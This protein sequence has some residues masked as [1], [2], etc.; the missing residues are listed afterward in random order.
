MVPGDVVLMDMLPYFESGKVNRKALQELYRRTTASTD[1]A[2]S[3]DSDDLR[4]I[5]DVLTATLEM[6]VSPDSHLTSM[7][8][9]SLSSIRLASKLSQAGLPRLDAAAL[10]GCTTPRDIEAHLAS[11]RD[12]VASNSLVNIAGHLSDL[13]EAAMQHES[14]V[15]CAEEVED[16]LPP[17]AV[18]VAMLNETVRDAHAYCNWI[19]LEIPADS[20]AAKIQRCIIQLAERHSLLRSGFAP[21]AGRRYTHALVTWKRLTPNQ[22]DVVGQFDR[23]FVISD[24]EQLL[25]PCNFQILPGEHGTRVLLCIHH[26]LYDQWSVDLMKLD[27]EALLRGRELDPPKLFRSVALHHDH[28]IAEAC[29]GPAMEFWQDQ[30]GSS[31]PS[32]L[33]LM[34]GSQVPSQV[35][36]TQW[37]TLDLPFRLFR[38]TIRDLG[39]SAPSVFQSALAYLLGC[40]TGS[41]DVTFASVFSGRNISV[42]GIDQVFGPCL[43]TLPVRVNYGATRTCRDLLRLVH[44]RNQAIQ[45]HVL[46]PLAQIMAEN[47][48][49]QGSRMFDTLFVWQETS[50]PSAQLVRE[51][52]SSDRNEFDLVVELEPRADA[53]DVRATFEQRLL[54]VEQ[55]KLL[56]RQLQAVV[57]VMLHRPDSAVKEL[58]EH[59]PQ[60][61]LS[62]GNASYSAA[63]V[64]RNLAH[65]IA[66]H[67]RTQPDAT[68]LEFFQRVD[69]GNETMTRVSYRDLERRTN[70]MAHFLLSVVSTPNELICICMDKSVEMYV[71]IVATVK[72]G[73]GYL[74]LVPGTPPKR[75][76]AVFAQTNVKMCICNP[77]LVETVQELGLTAIDIFRLD[78]EA[79]SSLL[80]IEQVSG[81]GVAYTVFTSGSTGQPKGVAVTMDNLLG[82]LQVLS[83][84]YRV[85]TG[86]RLL[87]ACSQAFDVSVFEIFFA[88]Y[89]GIALV[90][91]P[92]EVLFQDIERIIDMLSVTHL[93]LTPTVAAL[94]D[95]VKVPRVRFLVTAGEGMNGLV[96]RSWAGRGLHQGYG[97]SETTNICTIKMDMA[98]TD[99]RGNV[100]RPFRNTS[101]FVVSLDGPFAPLPSG[102]FGEFVFGGEQVFKGY[103]AMEQ[104][105]AEKIIHHPRF[106]RLYKS[107]DVGRLL[108]DGSLLIAGR[109]DDQ[110]KIRG[111]RVELGEIRAVLLE[112]PDVHDAAV[113]LHGKDAVEQMLAAFVVPRK[114]EHS[115][116][117]PSGALCDVDALDLARLYARLE[118]RLPAYMI[119][120]AIVPLPKMPVTSQGKL[121]QRSLDALLD[122]M[123]DGT[124]NRLRHD[125]G[126]AEVE[127]SWSG[128]EKCIADEV[129]DHLGMGSARITRGSSFFALGLNSL[130]AIALARRLSG[131]LKRNV[132]V[133]LI[134]KNPTVVRLARAVGEQSSVALHTTSAT[135]LPL[136]LVREVA[137]SS[138]T[139]S[140]NIEDTLPCTP[141]QQAMLSASAAKSSAYCNTVWIAIHGDAARVKQC[142]ESA[143]RRHGILRTVFPTTRDPEHPHVQLVLRSIDLPWYEQRPPPE[144]KLSEVLDSHCSQVTASVPFM[145]QLFD[146]ADGSYLCLQMHHAISDGVSLALMLQEVEQLYSGFDLAPAVSF[147]PFLEEVQHHNSDAA[148]EFWAS[149][150]HHFRPT[151]L[152]AIAGNRTEAV[153]TSLHE[154]LTVDPGELYCFCRQYGVTQLALFQAALMMTLSYS[155][156]ALDVCIGSVTSGRTVA[157]EG[158]ERLIAPCFNT[159]PV[160]MDLGTIT[161]IVDLVKKLTQLNV[162]LLPFQL[163]S[164]RR[165]QSFSSA[166]ATR[167]FDCLLLLQ[168][169][170]R[171]LDSDVWSIRHEDGEMNFP[172]VLEM[173]PDDA[174]FDVCWHHLQ[175]S[176]SSETVAKIQNLFSVVLKQCLQFP[177]AKIADNADSW[178]I[179]PRGFLAASHEDEHRES[180]ARHLDS[181][182]DSPWGADEDLVRCVFA[183]LARVEKMRVKKHTSMYQI[184]LDS[185]NAPQVAAKLRDRG[186]HVD[187]ADVMENLTPADIAAVARQKLSVHVDQPGFDLHA[188]DQQYRRTVLDTLNARTEDIEAVRPCTAV[189]C[190]MLAQSMQSDGKLYINHITYAMPEGASQSRIETA[191]RHVQAN[192]QILR[193]S[194]LHLEDHTAPFVMAVFRADAT[195]L[196]VLAARDTTSLEKIELDATKLIH[197]SP[198]VPAW[199][200]SIQMTKRGGYMM[201]SMSHALYD[202]ES[203]QMFA[204]DFYNTLRGSS[205]AHATSMDS[206]LRSTLTAERSHSPSTEAF[207]A[208]KVS[209]LMPSRFPD[210]TPTVVTDGALRSEHHVCSLQFRDIK[211][212]C[213][214]EEVTIQA[215]GQAA[216]ALLLSAYVGET[217][218]TFG[219]VLSGRTTDS[220]GIAFPSITTIPVPC[221]VDRPKLQLVRDML[222]FNTALQRHRHC[223]LSQIQQHAGCSG[224]SLFDTV[225]VY[226]RT[227]STKSSLSWPIVRET[228]GVEY[229]A[230]LEL[231]HGSGEDVTVRLTF[232]THRIPLEHGR[233]ILGQYELLLAQIV[234]GLERTAS[235]TH[236]MYSILPAKTPEITSAELLLHDFVSSGA[237][238]WP[239]S[240]ALEFV[241]DDD[242]SVE[243]WS[244]KQFDEVS[245]Q[246]AHLLIR[247]GVLPGSMVAVCMEKCP[248][249]SFAFV[250]ILKTGCSF[251][252]LDPDLPQSRFDFILQDSRAVLLLSNRE[253]VACTDA[254]RVLKIERGSLRDYPSGRPC[255]QPVSPDQTCYCLYT[256]GTTGTPKGCEITH[257]N[258]VQAMLAFQR[259]FAGHWT[260]ASRWLQFASYWF[261]VSVLEQFWSWSVGITVVGAPRDLI[262][263]NLTGFIESQRITHIDLT[264]SLARLVDPR[265]VPTLWGGVFITGGEALK[266]AIIDAWGSKRTVCNAYGPTEAT[267]GVTMN[268]FIGSAAK[269]S[270]I[271]HQFDNVGTY[272]LEQESD[273]PVMLGGV[274]EL[275]VAGK[276]VGKGYLNR[277]ELSAK[278]FP[279]LHRFGER[280][281]RT[282]DLV[283]MLAD[284]SFIFLGR[285]DSQA[286]LRGQRLEIDEIDAAIRDGSSDISGVASLVVKA[287]KGEKQTLVS[288]VASNSPDSDG[289]IKLQL[290]RNTRQT[291]LDAYHACRRRLPGY[292]VPSHIIPVSRLPL[293]ANN[294]S[295]DK[296]LASFFHSLS[297]DDV[298]QLRA[299]PNVKPATGAE[300]KICNLFCQVLGLDAEQLD[301]ETSLFSLGL[302]SISAITFASVLKR[303]GYNNATV[304]TVMKHATIADLASALSAPSAASRNIDD[305]VEQTKLWLRAYDQRHRSFAASVMSVNGS[306]IET[307]APCT[308]LQQG[309]IVESFKANR[310]PY[311][312]EFQ[313]RLNGVNLEKLKHSFQTL[314]DQVQVLRTSFIRT[315][316]G[317]AQVVLL[318]K[319]VSLQE[320]S[321]RADRAHDCLSECK[322][323]WIES[324]ADELVAPF[325]VHFV[326]SPSH[327]LMAIFVHHALYDG[328]SYPLLMGQLWRIYR[329]EPTGDRGPNFTVALPYG[330]LRQTPGA[331]HFWTQRLR[332]VQYVPFPR[333]NLIDKS[334]DS[335]IQRSQ[336]NSHSVQSASKQLGVPYQ[337][338]V[339]ACFELALAEILPSAQAYGLVISG[340]S[341]DLDDSD[342]VLGPMFNTLLQPLRVDLNSLF[343][344]HVRQCHDWM[345][346]TLPF[347]QSSLRDIRKW[348]NMSPGS[349]VFDILLVF[350]IQDAATEDGLCTQ[351][352]SNPIAEH[353]VTCEIE[354][355]STGNLNITLLAQ[356]E[357]LDEDTVMA[358]LET[359]TLLLERAAQKPDVEI[360]KMF[361]IVQHATSQPQQSRK[362]Q[363]LPVED[364]HESEWSPEA[365]IIRQLIAQVMELKEDDI[366]E[367]TSIFA[368]GMDSIDAVKLASRLKSVGIL[369]SVSDVMHCETITR[370]APV[371]RKK[372]KSHAPREHVNIR[373]VEKSLLAADIG[374]GPP[375]DNAD[376][377][378][379]L[380]ATSSQ[381]AIIAD[382]L[383]SEFRQYFNHD[384]LRLDRDLDLD[385]LKASWQTVVDASPILRTSFA[386]IQDPKIDFTFALCVHKPRP[387]RF[388]EHS[389]EDLASVQE[390]IDQIREDVRRTVHILPPLRLGIITVEQERY[391]ILALSHALYD[392]HSIAMLHDDVQRAYEKAYTSR[393]GID[394]A[395]ESA[396]GATEADAKH[397]WTASLSGSKAIGFPRRRSPV[398]RSATHRVQIR[399]P[400][401]ASTVRHF[402]KAQGV[403]IQALA[404]TCWAITL[405]HHVRSLEVLFGVVMACRDSDDEQRIMFPMMNTVVFRAVMHGLRTE[406][407]RFMQAKGASLRR[408]QRTPL[409]S[410]QKWCAGMIDK[411]SSI[412]DNAL[413]D[414]LFI[415]QHRHGAGGVNDK[416]LYQSVE[417]TSDIEYP[418]AV[419]MEVL[420][421]ELFIRAACKDSVFDHQGTVKLAQ[422]MSEVLSV[423]LTDPDAPTVT[424]HGELVSLCGLPSFSPLSLASTRSP[425]QQKPE[426]DPAPEPNSELE[427]RIMLTLAQVSG[428]ALD[429]MTPRSTIESIGIDSISA[430]KVAA[431]LRKE[432]LYLTVSDI[433]QHKTAQ[434]MARAECSKSKRLPSAETPGS[435]MIEARRRPYDSH[436]ISVKAGVQVAD[437][438]TILPATS[439]QVYLL[440]LWALTHG[441]TF[442]SKFTYRINVETNRGQIESAWTALV[443]HHGI[444]RTIFCTTEDNEEPVVQVVLRK[445]TQTVSGSIASQWDSRSKQLMSLHYEE[446]DL[447]RLIHLTIHHALYDA[448]SL[449]LLMNDFSRLLTDRALTSPQLTYADFLALSMGPASHER[450]KTFWQAYFR[451]AKPVKLLQPAAD[452]H[453]G[454]VEALDPSLLSNMSR[455]ER[456]ARRNSISTQALLFAAYARAYA[457]LANSAGLA[458]RDDRDV[459]IGIYLANRAHLPDLASLPCPTLNLVPLRV[460]TPRRGSLM[461]TAQQIH[462]DL[463]SFGTPE[464]SS[465]GLWQIWQWTGVKV[466]TF[467]NF[468]RLPE[469]T[470]LDAPDRTEDVITALDGERLRR[471]LEVIEIEESKEAFNLQ[472]SLSGLKDLEGYCVS[473]YSV[474]V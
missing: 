238:H 28:H 223:S 121:D 107:G 318:Q 472:E 316:E 80:Q 379:M 333:L 279:F 157:I 416:P 380:P 381:E 248:E 46:T 349:P 39:V 149:Q 364:N 377:E 246:V 347:Q 114:C 177:L 437:I 144:T 293:T 32:L 85:Q 90:S 368:L 252:A 239:D 112:D 155:Q 209:S 104:L 6:E 77:G 310:R 453:L 323:Q 58:A 40:Y 385:R 339:Q 23:N 456:I 402:C 257:E 462:S 143:S 332:G 3:A 136:D 88:F 399:V 428:V 191:W 82:N 76:Q 141:L 331:K 394:G 431:S 240:V 56:F 245:N 217:N 162:D 221:F 345:V 328:I 159:V 241:Y 449:P 447:G 158:V 233:A 74:P 336:A 270:N 231:E 179:G 303:S 81:S 419:E 228:S 50:L 196:P 400:V 216:W 450:A 139:D 433:I 297:L 7:G 2:Q 145:L 22:V 184:G 1:G 424:L 440:K 232:D 352:Q 353:P 229:V 192:H 398:E 392:G 261:D 342:K 17:T 406:M 272:V 369:I 301:K 218:V 30:L 33:P 250:G 391:L 306:A 335:R 458:N 210:L 156:N 371:A 395:I 154:R 120:G 438:E 175:P 59:L 288:F 388:I 19:E 260:E 413:F 86:D 35:T 31:S 21:L 277:P 99:C 289:D 300:I 275:C 72:I 351:V 164:L 363:P 105:N 344:Q 48:P 268:T 94:V 401:P 65:T 26:S 360:V 439:G 262:L 194:L 445:P 117:L 172:L 376:I 373:D 187:A 452:G 321:L 127:S 423:I 204:E 167:L 224:Q 327:M 169:P 375:D 426:S 422:R 5:L 258:A 128:V 220:F 111:N 464:I 163:A 214:R 67:A 83:E 355:R 278:A 11:S 147:R 237:A 334:S 366:H 53:I 267:I 417:G 165:L 181:P 443:Q 441:R 311:F 421:D 27:L 148:M 178:D 265:D 146:L 151:Q 193:T 274:G 44:E 434:N 195:A 357:Y 64:G 308:P 255:I 324:N 108:P 286:K 103:V 348:S 97:P 43:A 227:A 110:V 429:G 304:A 113:T 451:S 212:F 454:R 412:P 305:S 435:A 106:G 247:K 138:S 469:K 78:L 466:D 199:R 287:N 340:R 372:S 95:P 264:P 41:A 168:P 463:E 284:G 350:Q 202:A 408:H 425:Q 186:L 10:Q 326:Q 242:G 140:S 290:S 116:R 341:I 291:V 219:T 96:H 292:M 365:I 183:D 57:Q 467:V 75:M 15:S 471:R 115:T 166:S 73:C 213:R 63:A 396:L 118:D 309:M 87:Q 432:G 383:R 457:H 296:R 468:L 173:T 29:S 8:L 9:D 206:L 474:L 68:A 180:G 253:S 359:L 405:A 70:Q 387:L 330:P 455:L 207:W 315:D 266:Q 61:I 282:G 54:P 243:R 130:G 12:N 378:R 185:L 79:Y 389:L 283:R 66:A 256:S 397:F 295:D 374:P 312:N 354:L 427:R 251:L 69:P 203:L 200:L 189:Q 16:V 188:F 98:A 384:I 101:V 298:Q 249:A 430:I 71:A 170:A 205:I 211:A 125:L 322:N 361:D 461:T 102:A 436:A 62:I 37:Q 280:V 325:Q 132:T 171:R 276:L 174:G 460:R 269:P 313:Y 254:V 137:S 222:E 51:V 225:F 93:S 346:K 285:L 182:S 407:L 259:L 343:S 20:A 236:P 420:S 100:G 281:Y 84:L 38:A 390:V 409:R 215:V 42:Q 418:V 134:L 109:V 201:L 337:A 60:E 36:Q 91:A 124:R 319:A 446:K 55:I 317:H 338:L 129:A 307:V 244:Y 142:W 263:E 410:I 386:E 49:A 448:V 320:H 160:R 234:G 329:E 4:T 465:V 122:D 459:V 13:R 198:H 382:M 230:S 226:Q 18:Q 34:S 14:I 153:E 358:L 302:S 47:P 176:I 25:R 119:P 190:G 126:P 123:E 411:D 314:A 52:Q 470:A 89:T 414:S 415:Y 135:L 299:A 197:G 367:N 271:G 362:D 208:S 273:E 150:L 45:R 393:P 473:P 403:S 152:V 356:Q 370:M 161:R 92:K 235:F 404:Q 133:A 131:V 24:S 444:L 294:K 442:R